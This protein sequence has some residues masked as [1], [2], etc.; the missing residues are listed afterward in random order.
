[1]EY[2]LG[3]RVARHRIRRPHS[4]RG[5]TQCQRLPCTLLVPSTTLAS[6]IALASSMSR[7]EARVGAVTRPVRDVAPPHAAPPSAGRPLGIAPVGKIAAT[8]M[9]PS[10]ETGPR[11][12]AIAKAWRDDRGAF[13]GGAKTAIA[14]AN[15]AIAVGVAPSR[16]VACAEPSGGDVG[17]IVEAGPPSSAGIYAGPKEPAPLPPVAPTR[18]GKNAR[19]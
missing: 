3:L 5:A 12:G 11:K 14:E 9:G 7:P 6:S 2:L 1:M 15:A 17:A 13:T 18:V 19:V 8:R 16:R 4:R 10:S